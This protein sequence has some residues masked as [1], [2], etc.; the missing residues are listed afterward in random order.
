MIKTIQL[1]TNQDVMDAQL[2]FYT[3]AKLADAMM[4]VYP[5]YCLE[6]WVKLGCCKGDLCVDD[7]G[8]FISFS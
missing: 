5:M 2:S 3:L 8:N 6:Q 7:L 1:R 4:C